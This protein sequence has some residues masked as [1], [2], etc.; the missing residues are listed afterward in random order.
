MQLDVG[1]LYYSFRMRT[2]SSS[3]KK[4]TCG[5]STYELKHLFNPSEQ[6]II[7]YLCLCVLHVYKKP[8]NQH[9]KN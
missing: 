4:N 2:I 1:A 8:T 9:K 7:H 5:D 6:V 3:D